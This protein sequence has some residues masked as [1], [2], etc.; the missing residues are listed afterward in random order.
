MAVGYDILQPN[1]IVKKTRS[2]HYDDRVNL[3]NDLL[4]E[5]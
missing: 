4:A 3:V 5:W 2:E 1:G